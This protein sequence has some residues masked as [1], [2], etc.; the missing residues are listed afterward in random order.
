VATTLG[1]A[2]QPRVALTSSDWQD[3]YSDN[4]GH[5]SQAVGGPRGAPWNIEVAQGGV[6][7][8]AVRRWPAELDLALTATV[9]R[10]D[11]RQLPIAA[12]KLAIQGKEYAAKAAAPDAKEIVFRVPLG[13]GATQLQA[14]F[15]DA[16]GE[17]LSGAFY[18]Y[19]KRTQ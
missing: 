6:Y 8:F 11:A 18:A 2:K 13:P 4:A 7:E 12:A 1:S 19:V 10:K 9:P 3:V 14:W 15:Q 17:D 16:K 5:V